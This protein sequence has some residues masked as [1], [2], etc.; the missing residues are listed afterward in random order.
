MN[1]TFNL[2]VTLLCDTKKRQRIL[3]CSF[4]LCNSFNWGPPRVF[5]KNKIAAKDFQLHSSK[6]NSVKPQS[7][8]GIS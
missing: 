5:S 6:R 7:K 8:N 4:V 3:N 1:Q 2:A